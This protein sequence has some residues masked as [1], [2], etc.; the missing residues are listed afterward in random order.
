MLFWIIS[1][2]LAA[3][4][5]TLLAI[6]LLRGRSGDLAPAAY[7][8]KVYKDQL[9]EVERDLKRGVIRAEDAARLKTE[10]S[11]RILGADAQ[12]RSEA[13]PDGKAPRISTWA[14]VACVL[15]MTGGAAVTYAM[16]GAADYPD[17]PLQTRIADAAERLENR[18]PQAEA[19]AAQ[20][21]PVPAEVDPEFLTLMEELRR[22]VAARPDDLEGHRL[23][24]R[25]EGS[26]GNFKAAYQAQERVIALRGTAA[27]SADYVQLADLMVRA[28][29]GYVSPE[30]DQAL[31][32][33]LE[34]D[35]ENGFARYYTGLM[36]TQTGRPDLTFRIWSA[37]LE[38]GPEAAPWIAPIRAR[39]DDLA[40]IAGVNYTAPDPRGPSAEDVAAAESLDA[41]SR[42]QMI[43][44]MVA[45]LSERLAS[46]GGSPAEWAQLIVALAVQGRS[47]DSRAIWQEAQDTF[48]GNADALAILSEAAARAGH[49]Q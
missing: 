34:R 26:L 21:A 14:A 6:T 38:R 32:A 4:I 7:D 35:P 48:A 47:E 2:G 19:E 42:A 39:I 22:K 23:L 12:L 17:M 36:L 11:R 10:I 25:N 29:G 18:P 5:S 27:S 13:D 33:A 24:A 3:I 46:E 41:E 31:R 49:E 40:W 1:L 15:F 28:A 8:L 43:N 37:L 16:I 45:G 30:A 20:P 44:A 9:S